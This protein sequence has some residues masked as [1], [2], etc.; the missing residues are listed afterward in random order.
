MVLI[1][2]GGWANKTI[3][4]YLNVWCNFFRYA[5]LVV[6]GYRNFSTDFLDNRLP[7]QSI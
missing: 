2:T 6:H 4:E 1:T 7:K 3:N 5:S